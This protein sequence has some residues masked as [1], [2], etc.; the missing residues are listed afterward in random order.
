MDVTAADRF[1]VE[2]AAELYGLD[3]WSNSYVS[4]ARDGHLIMS[5]GRNPE[6]GIDVYDRVY[7]SQ[8]FYL[9]YD[10]A[11]LEY[12]LNQ[13]LIPINGWQSCA[14]TYGE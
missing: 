7:K 6:H 5:P 4:I 14:A 11:I 10:L 9:I 3:G 13:F 2:H 12:I 8:L 1:T